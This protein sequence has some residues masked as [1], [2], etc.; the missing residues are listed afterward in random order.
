M[1]SHAPELRPTLAE[2][3]VFVDNSIVI[4]HNVNFDLSFLRKHGI[5]EENPVHR[6]LRPGQCSAS[7]FHPL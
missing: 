3:A 4:G 6:Y 2:I 5:L 7:N 1:V